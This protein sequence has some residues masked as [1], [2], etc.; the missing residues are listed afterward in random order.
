VIVELYRQ[1]LEGKINLDERYLLRE[2]DKTLGSGVL[3]HLQEG[4]NPTIRDLAKLMMTLSDNTAT[5]IIMKMLG[6]E[7]RTLKRLRRILKRGR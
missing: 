6:Q 3:Q 4:L 5:D 1:A 2:T 7:P